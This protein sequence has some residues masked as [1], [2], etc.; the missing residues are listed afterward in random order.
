MELLLA[1]ENVFQE[2]LCPISPPG[3]LKK[4]RVVVADVWVIRCAVM[5]RLEQGFGALDLVTNLN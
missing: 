4:H 5:C 3:S 2:A 1:G